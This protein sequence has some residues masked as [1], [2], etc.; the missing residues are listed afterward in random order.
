MTI[1]YRGIWLALLA[2]VVWCSSIGSPMIAQSRRYDA[3]WEKQHDLFLQLPGYRLAQADVDAKL[4]AAW[5]R[6]S[7]QNPDGDRRSCAIKLDAADPGLAY[8]DVNVNA[9]DNSW[10][11]GPRACTE[12]QGWAMMLAVQMGDKPMFDRLWRFTRK[13]MQIRSFN[14]GAKRGYYFAWQCL[15]QP[16]GGAKLKSVG[17]G[18]AP[19][20]ETW[21]AAA[22]C[23]AAG[24]WSEE[25]ANHYQEEADHIL[26]TMLHIDA[27]NGYKKN[28][29][30]D[31]I[32]PTDMVNMIQNNQVCYI[33][34]QYP[35]GPK[36]ISSHKLS[37]PSY[38]LPAFYEIFAKRGSAA[39]RTT[40][41]RIA[42]HA[43]TYYL[44]R[45][46]GQSADSPNDNRRTAISPFITLLDGTQYDGAGKDTGH[47][48]SGD[49]LRTP[50]NIGVDYLW[51][52]D[53][54]NRFAFHTKYADTALRFLADPTVANPGM[55]ISG[56]SKGG[57]PYDYN[58]FWYGVYYTDGR[59][60][61][62]ANSPSQGNASSNHNEASTA[63]NAVAAQAAADPIKWKFVEELWGCNQPCRSSANRQGT[64]GEPYWDGTLYM[65]GL[66]E[67]AGKFKPYL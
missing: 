19:D 9:P 21:I 18:P 29:D 20:G 43:R 60:Y 36:H 17:D 35:M 30:G 16:K 12:G 55:R 13:Y 58:R 56:F 50:S 57:Y 47:I 61:V 65:L 44:P 51:W 3:E 15:P 4:R 27:Q 49:G 14:P 39:D 52:N 10:D 46:T 8:A 66:L 24:R 23:C 7:G 40:W 37:D 67:T 26:D 59:D 1:K 31:Y 38:C 62:I 41:Q 32:P 48:T 33:P 22:L 28:A 34:A 63:M 54:S 64:Y 2:S 11:G 42:N 25:R 5:L 53:R 6:Y 45:A